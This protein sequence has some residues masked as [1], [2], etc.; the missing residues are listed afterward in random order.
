MIYHLF[1][2]LDS[3][4]DI[5]GIGV[6]QYLSFRTVIVFVVSMVCTI[7]FGKKFI[8]FFR[9]KNIVE[10]TR[11]LGLENADEKRATPS[12]GGVIIIF[13]ILLSVFLFADIT[14]VY[15]QVLMLTTVIMGIIGGIDDYIKIFK[16]N[17]K[18]IKGKYKVY[19]QIIIGLMTGLTMIF[20]ESIFIRES[21]TAENGEKVIHE[22]KE[23]IT[24]L[25]LIKYNYINYSSIFSFFSE[26]VMWFLGVALFLFV[27]V[28]IVS[29]VSNGLNLTDGLDGLAAGSVAISSSVLAVFAYLIGNVIF[30]EYLLLLYIPGAGEIAIFMAAIVGACMGFLWYNSHPAQVFM[31]DVG[32]L[33]L[34]AIMGVTALLLRKEFLLPI[35]CGVFLIEALSVIL[36]VSYFKYTKKRFGKGKRIWKMTPIHHHFQ[37][38]GWK[39]QKVVVRF[40]IIGIILA[41]I[42]LATIKLR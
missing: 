41:G 25:P 32:S 39:E 42:T 18:G 7:I 40:W 14:N 37:K 3:E 38:K 35:L 4:F 29:S 23:L 8:T 21:I 33:T 34:G 11:E 6:F 27:C 26:N 13:S 2:F 28:F 5:P 9:K 19:G 15:I 24:S 31:G 16:S 22:T 36:Q 12:M 30:S 1:K 17:K 10:A 20:H